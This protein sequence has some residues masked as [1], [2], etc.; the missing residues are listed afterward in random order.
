MT[1]VALKGLIARKTRAILTALA[2]VLGVAM[3]A[4]TLI[5]TDS[6]QRAF[7]AVFTTSYARTD[8]VVSA[9]RGTGHGTPAVTAGTLAR[10][11]RVPGVAL[12]TGELIDFGQMS[13]AEVLDRRGR[14]IDANGMT[15]AFGIDPTQPR[16]NPLTLTAGR[17]ARGPA[18]I[19]LDSATAD[20]HGFRLGDQV[21]VVARG[22][23]S[24][25][26]LV[27][28]AR[29]GSVSSIGATVAVLDVP[30]AQRLLGQPG[31]A[32]I[33]VAAAP[34]VTPAD[35]VHRIQA[36]LP[37]TFVVK[38][39]NQQARAAAARRA[40][41]V[42]IIRDILLAFAAIALF[43]GAFVILN[44]LA[45]TVAQRTR[46]LA[47]LRT[48]GAT[49][50]QVLRSVLTE[51]AGIGVI[52]SLAGLALGFVLARGLSWLF[53]AVGAR[54]P[55]SG[56][57]VTPGTVV[58]CF[59]VGI[60]VTV[61][62][63]I[64]PALRAT[65]VAAI[66]AVREGSDVAASRGARGGRLVGPALTLASLV[67]LGTAAAGGLAVPA[68]LVLLGAG[69]VGLFG[70]AVLLAREL[71]PPL[72]GAIGWPFARLGGAA[73]ALARRNAT[74]NPAR[75]AA[76]ASAL[77]IGIGL[78][79]FVAILAGALS[80]AEGR[81]VRQQVRAPYV[82][83]PTASDNGATF[84]M[85]VARRITAG[86]G[87]EATTVRVASARADGATVSVSGI[88]P[89]H[90][91]AAYRF[92]WVQG[93]DSVLGH[94]GSSGVVVRDDFATS[95]HLAVGS[96]VTIAGPG[97]RLVRRVEAVYRPPI[98]DPLLGSI[99]LPRPSFDAAFPRAGAGYTFLDAP[100]TP[101]ERGRLSGLLGA[102]SQA[103]VDTVAQFVDGR[104]SSF[105]QTLQLV[106]VLL[107]LS[108]V[109]SV[110]GMV[111][112]LVLS[113][114]ERTRELGMLRAVGLTRRQTRRLIRQESIITALIGSTIGVA[115]GSILAV[116]AARAL[117][118]Y[119]VSVGL[120]L[121]TI[122]EFGVIGVSIGVLAAAMPA[123]RAARLD[124]LAA[125]QY[126]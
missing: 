115:V 94:L 119:G 7:S 52:A 35:V 110:F 9:R 48:L 90:L 12:A 100:V 86:F 61:V 16:F 63:A 44:T 55:Q 72:A 36:A 93:S 75:T 92:T 80:G 74:R 78:I 67:S 58:A 82:V 69:T 37:R 18:E 59:A 30:A 26:R 5:L 45:I 117:A 120:P 106:Y 113:T 125:L 89:A 39:G 50:R 51:A 19:V 65:R 73:G 24:R 21:A 40:H 28:E 87:A 71:V 43:V 88:D 29:F 57:A 96:S 114:F 112:T 22:L 70:G 15:F 54:A 23:T 32:S 76:T 10:V 107:S 68:R 98:F 46:E 121:R 62:A 99:L 97:G 83:A 38:T 2:V 103:R 66:S 31:Y 47:T 25:Y 33:S 124:V 104:G 3:I 64:R 41:D 95:H 108:V 105:R 123:R 85:A 81:A 77:M 14:V 111:N 17:W 34:G 42:A 60:A 122:I 84:P 101:A 11:R 20:G 116:V 6:I 49:R 109:V 102:G 118:R 4:G 27:G 56:L 8:A 13:V 91:A 126:E 1:R 53:S 79:S